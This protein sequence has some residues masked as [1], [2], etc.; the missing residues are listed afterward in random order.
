MDMVIDVSAVLAVI[1]NEPE[2]NRV[3]QLTSGHSLTGPAS[4]P[5]EV[6]NAFSSMLKQKRVTIDEVL[7]GI[8][9]FKS[10]PIR[11]LKVDFSKALSIAHSP[12]MYAYDA[13]FL[14]CAIRTNAPLL[15][16]DKRL[17]RAAR[18]LGVFLLEI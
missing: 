10:I 16:L 8:D 15:T 9:F 2:R 12:K 13:Y 17:Q 18:A 5:R 7:R 6:G 11:Y 14:D 1:V 3:I 4:I